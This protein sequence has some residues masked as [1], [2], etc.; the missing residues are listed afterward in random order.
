MNFDDYSAED[1][2]LN[3]RFQRWVQ[4]PDPDTER[5]WQDWLAR[6][7]DKQETITEARQLVALLNFRE[8]Q[9][10]ADEQAAVWNRLNTTRKPGFSEQVG[11]RPLWASRRWMGWAA[12]MAGMVF[13]GTLL[14]FFNRPTS[15]QYHTEYGQTQTITLP[16]GSEVI[17]NAHSNLKLATDWQEGQTR[18]VWLEGEAFFKVVQKQRPS[19]FIV[20]TSDLNVEVLGTQFNVDSRKGATQVV[21][22]SGQVKLELPQGA[23]RKSIVMAP[24]E[25]V[26]FSSRQKTLTK[27]TVKPERYSDWTSQQW[28]L[29]NTSLREVADRLEKTFGLKV[30][31][32]DPDIAQERMSGVVPAEN[33]EDLIDALSTTNTLQIS[34]DE[35]QLYI[36][37]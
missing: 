13:L 7:P 28:I 11:V 25:L 14:Y 34:R 23:D 31:F 3:E 35:N 27:R 5:F 33:L 21:L 2:A 1:F 17:L 32:A 19:R 9:P 26:E 18:E 24:G 36:S 8:D 20:H 4:Q 22:N 12:A 10:A 6:H 16:D 29:D 37:R 30:T 15:P